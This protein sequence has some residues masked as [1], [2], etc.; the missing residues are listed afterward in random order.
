MVFDCV[1]GYLLVVNSL[2]FLKLIK[3]DNIGFKTGTSETKQD[4]EESERK[5]NNG[6]KGFVRVDS[7]NANVLGW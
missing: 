2:T 5:A 7:N 6:E 4:K 1:I 3:R